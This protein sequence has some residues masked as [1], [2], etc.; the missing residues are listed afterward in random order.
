M[1]ANYS[2]FIIQIIKISLFR[3]FKFHFFSKNNR[4]YLLIPNIFGFDK[5]LFSGIITIGL[6][7]GLI[8]GLRIGIRIG[9]IM[10]F[11]IGFIIR[12]R[13]G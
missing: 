3:F 5:I 1:N 2:N 11:R 6:T 9:F 13:I 12:F 7:I 8:I 4:F 10:R